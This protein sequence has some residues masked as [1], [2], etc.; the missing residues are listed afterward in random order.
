MVRY[1]GSRAG[2]RKCFLKLKAARPLLPPHLALTHLS[3]YEC[4]ARVVQ[5]G[6][7]WKMHVTSQE[8]PFKSE[9]TRNLGI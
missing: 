3:E 7:I 2:K 1:T 9:N 8:F 5:Y 6:E 4:T